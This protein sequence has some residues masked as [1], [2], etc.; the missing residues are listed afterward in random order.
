MV[1]KP[2]TIVKTAEAT[3][4]NKKKETK[5]GSSVNIVFTV[6][7]RD[8][9]KKLILRVIRDDSVND[10]EKSYQACAISFTALTPFGFTKAF[11]HILL[12]RSKIP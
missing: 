7:A 9:K 3:P 1:R 8:V 10:F 12:A 11:S 5:V 6:H 2:S 4:L